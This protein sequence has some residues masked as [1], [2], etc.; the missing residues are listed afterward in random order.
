MFLMAMLLSGGVASAQVVVKGNVYG[1]GELGKVETN[2][3]VTINA[4]S[5]TEG[6]VFGGGKGDTL[7]ATAGAV[8][9]NTLV[10]M[11]GGSVERSI[12]G[13]GAYGSVGTF[14]EF[15]TVVYT[16]SNQPNDTA[17]VPKTCSSGGLAKV[18]VCGGSVGVRGSLMPWSDHNP[19][20][21]DRG[22]IFCG[23]QGHADSILS[24][25]AVAL[26]VVDSTYLEI[27]G[28]NG[29]PVITASVYGGCENGLVLGNTY[30]KIMGGQIGTGFVSKNEVNHVLVGQWDEKYHDT[31][32]DNATTYVREENIAQINRIA[33]KFHECDAW[34]FGDINNHYNVYDILDSNP[35]T[36]SCD[37]A[38][39]TGQSFFGNVFGGGSGYYPIATGLW[40]HTA[41]QVNG[42]TTVEITGGH[43]LTNVYG[44]NEITDVLGKTTVVM[45][46]GT[47]GIPRTQNGIEGRPLSG[48]LYGAGKGDPRTSFNTKTNV[49]S[50]VVI[51]NGGVIF[52]SVYGGGED[53]HVIK[54]TKVTI[55]ETN[56]AKPLVIGTFGFTEHEGNVFGAG[57][58]LYRY[59][60]TAGTV[61]GNTNIDIKS[62]IILGNVYGGGTMASVGTY[63][64]ESNN[65]QLYGQMQSGPEHGH[66]TINI[67]GGTIG[68]NYEAVYHT[69]FNQ[70]SHGGNV[71]GGSKGAVMQL[72]SNTVNDIWLNLAKV[73]Q[74]DITIDQS[75]G[76]TTS[77]KGNIY[78]GGEFG[79]VTENTYITIENGT[80]WR[81]VYG[82]GHGDD[83]T[84]DYGLSYTPH[85]HAGRVYGNTNIAVNGGWIKKSVYG[86][87]ELA[88][89]GTIDID[90]CEATTL[91]MSWP[92][93]FVYDTLSDGSATGKTEITVRGGRIGTTGKDFMGPWKYENNQW[94]PVHFENGVAVAY[95][96]TTEDGREALDD[97]CEDNGDIYGGSKGKAMAEANM[98]Y[99]G[100][101][102]ETVITVSYPITN[103]ATPENY[104]PK[105]ED[106]DVPEINHGIGYYPTWADWLTWVNRP[107][108]HIPGNGSQACITG[109]VYGGAEEGHVDE[110]TQI[111]LNNGLVGH[112]I[113]GGGKGKGKVG[114]QPIPT[115]GKVYGN[116]N[117][118]IEGGYVVRS[119]FGGGNLASVGKGNYI[120][121]E[122]GENGTISSA[123]L[124]AAASSGIATIN[125]NGGQLGMLPIDTV[126][127]GTLDPKSV[128]KD[129]IPYG[130]VFGG[131]RGQVV[132]PH[133]NNISDDFFGFI[134]KTDVTIGS[135]TSTPGKPLIYGSVYGG[136]QDGHVRRKTNVT[137]NAGEIGLEYVDST[138]AVNALGDHVYTSDY[139]NTR[140]NVYG[141]GSGISQYK[142]AQD[143]K[144]YS[145][146]AGMSYDSAN[147]TIN[148]GVIHRIVYGGGSLASV[149]GHSKVTINSPIG[150]ASNNY[151]DVTEYDY[152]GYVFGAGRGILNSEVDLFNFATTGSTEVNIASDEAVVPGNVYG[153]GAMGQVKGSTDV[154]ITAG[155]VGT[156][157]YDWKDSTKQHQFYQN[158]YPMDTLF[159]TSGGMVFGGGKGDK[160]F[161]D[162][163]LVRDSAKVTL[164]GGQ[165][166]FNIYGGGEVAS[167]GLRDAVYDSNNEIVDFKPKTDSHGADSTGL[168][169][170]TLLGG[171]V[172]PSP[173]VGTFSGQAYNIPNGLNGLDGFVFGGGKG[174][175]DDPITPAN[176]YGQYYELA[177]V[178]HTLVIMNMDMPTQSDSISNRLWGSIYGGAEDGHVL[179]S[180]T[181]RYINGLLGSTGTSGFDGNIFGGGRNDSK[182]NYSAGRTRGNNTVEMTG[183]QIF[184][185]IYGGGRLALTGV[186][187]KGDQLDGT[188]Y[189]HT[190][191]MVKG[192]IVGN[193]T[194]TNA[195]T[196][197][198]NEM[199]VEV[200]SA[201]SMGSIYGGGR[202]DVSGIDG[203]PAASALRLGLVKNTEV[204]ISDTLG[205]N[206]H[207]YGIVF[208]GGEVANV[209][210]YTWQTTNNPSAPPT[211]SNITLTE[212][213][214]KVTISGGT[215]GGDR[216]KMRYEK[217]P[218]PK[219]NI[220]P[221]YN[222]D[223]GY[224]YGGGEGISDNPKY[225]PLVQEGPNA[226]DATRLVNLFATVNNTEV[227]VSGGWVKGSV[228]GGAEAGHVRGNTLV[229]I[230]GGQIGAGDDTI[231]KKDWLYQDN[232][233]IRPDTV[234][235]TEALSLFGTTHWRFGDT[236]IS[237]PGQANA[238]TTVYYPPYDPVLARIDSIP[239]DGKSWFGN[240]F[241][242]GSGWFPYIDTLFKANGG[243]DTIRSRWNPLCGKV[244]GNTH[245]VVEGGHILNNVYGAN[246]ATDIGG[247]AL[248][249]IKGG[250][251]GVPRTKEQIIKQPCSGYVFGG[252]CGDPREVFDT[253]TLVDSTTVIVTGG[254]IYGSVYGGAED[255]HV[256][257][258]TSVTVNQNDGTTVIGCAGLS[259]A[260]GNIFGGGRNF[261]GGNRCAGRIEGNIAVTM[262]SGTILGSI[263][264]GGRQALAG[265]NAQGVFPNNA[266]AWPTDKHGN[267]TINV[268]GEATTSGGVT[269]YTTVIGNGSDQGIHL[270]TESDESVGDIFGSGKGDT[271]NYM[272][273]V[274]GRVTNATINITGS[275]RIHGA[276]FGGGEMASL[277]WWNNTGEFYDNTGEAIVTIGTDRGNDNPVIGTFLEQDPNYL[278]N[279]FNIAGITKRS[280]W[281]MIEEVNGATRLLHSC[282]GNVFGGCQGD[283]DFEDWDENDN[284][285]WNEW[286]HMGRSRTAT[287]TIYGGTIMSNV[288]G[289][290][291]QGVVAGDTRVSI[292]GGTIGKLLTDSQGEP[293]K[294]G[295]VY[296]AGYGSDDAQED[297]NVVWAFG[298]RTRTDS[299][300]GRTFG[301]S[302][303]NILG[304]TI[305]NSVFGGGAFAFVG[306]DNNSNT[307]DATV[308]IG[309]ATHDSYSVKGNFYGGNNRRG[310]VEGD[311]TVNVNAGTIGTNTT[312]SDVF[313]GGYGELTKTDGNVTVNFGGAIDENS[314]ASTNPT[315][316]GDIYGGS[317]YGTVNND[318]NDKTT[319]NIRNGIIKTRVENSIRYGGD[320]Y[321]GGL[322]VSG[323]SQKGVVY[324]KI[325]VN[326]GDS[327]HEP[328]VTV[329]DTSRYFGFATIENNVYG[330]NNTGGS[331]KADAI[332]NIFGTDH[333]TANSITGNEFAID[334]VFGGGN[335]APDTVSGVTAYVNIFGCDNTIRRVFGGGD[336]SDS[337]NVCTDIQGGRF[338]AVFGGGNGE[339]YSTTHP[340]YAAEILGN[341][342]LGIHGGEVA[343]FFAGSNQH[344]VIHGTTTVVVDS[345]GPCAEINI[346][347]FFCG[348]N[349]V[350]IIG[351]VNATIDC[352]QG[353]TVSNLYGGCN[354]AKILKRPDGTGG[355]VFLTVNGGT[356]KNIY[357]GSKG[358]I[359]PDNSSNNFS[360]DI[361]GDIN[362][363][364]QGGTIDTIFG[365]CNILGNVEGKIT[366]NVIDTTN[367]CDLNIYNVYGGGR[368]AAYAPAHDSIKI[369]SPEVNIIHGTVIKEA[370]TV[371]GETLY[372]GNVF[373]GGYHADITSSPKVTIGYDKNAAPTNLSN[374]V[375]TWLTTSPSTPEATVEG[376]VYGAGHEATVVGNP[377][378][379]LNGASKV[380][381][382]GNVYGGG[383]NAQVTGNAKVEIKEP[384]TQP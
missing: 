265:V 42:N 169:M 152:G 221:R 136:G 234:F 235:I 301:N 376:N 35:N 7:V 299:L 96:I 353:M 205:H 22:W 283:V 372:T 346:D 242:G 344:G 289:G 138:H 329:A 319:V 60:L 170:V 277:G 144:H 116:T 308:N 300:A 153:G 347:E 185:N 383:K 49:D 224:V 222:D 183:G 208:G 39:Y 127:G 350:N 382:K 67:T 207:V 284:T 26:G 134:N 292:Y 58:G 75:A 192:G 342:A 247:N 357:G 172:G 282:T 199:V 20:D 379:I 59:A 51:V 73:K 176:L 16:Y 81:D 79:T 332:V 21:D 343:A 374:I 259:T 145:P 148:G 101:V 355:N 198:P 180:D 167:V 41:G 146:I 130:S 149:E 4:N 32:W 162:A 318:G 340:E 364:I 286:P 151:H 52:G 150:V 29:N 105:K 334:Q 77:I 90:K 232:Q 229:K 13:G 371:N 63:L 227:T 74:T 368:G 97:A 188:G 244:W 280:E 316:W 139:W 163:G 327:I 322:G 287:V 309:D 366:V 197:D 160:G 240:V 87:G 37:T 245:V 233:F 351:D 220:Y 165:V 34:D 99:L 181:V 187:M 288:H 12:Y 62:G 72:N 43:I 155:I 295:N 246:E 108:A 310:S 83:D 88:S 71:F 218:D 19:N 341:A 1:G 28:Q 345:T 212:G 61:S 70:F 354:R 377:H 239:S 285:T 10:E 128:V 360:A 147:V 98:L 140:G 164:R 330:C 132:E 253:I 278:T 194:K 131:C 36:Y 256:L 215:I 279:N 216:A 291:E 348:G 209:G 269:T 237:N 362:L 189:G 76:K 137:V 210:K 252:G 44:G 100:N 54:G 325:L 69:D 166:L 118:T 200:F 9:G 264:G 179:G 226:T 323:D 236:I 271:K 314:T 104:K 373:G 65:T 367:A 23:S 307:G 375:P 182:K 125:I 141:G 261:L 110:N 56:P 349:Y 313:G 384:T 219:Y 3:T 365:G 184:G 143:K 157:A 106:F 92:Y 18:L 112:A 113:Y 281:T 33:G 358:F 46:G 296:G 272:D 303:V 230:Q 202:G 66:V 294:F 133:N 328:G 47:I 352:S 201:S 103:D 336:A 6:S 270:L 305:H 159:H 262:T 55:E 11:K 84:N 250:T 297:G 214:A 339:A 168:A 258:S 335:Y 154:K 225:Y 186:D 15:D 213:L 321:G 121:L 119:V 31:L 267:V 338:A 317:A 174:I 324:G 223:L 156:I 290:S 178:N 268:S 25:Q 196:Q 109:A 274:A 302:I 8:H 260:D 204:E 275:P 254:I 30:V 114:G 80:I 248:V 45:S 50:A 27:G 82:A 2:T 123:D 257:G 17:F 361:E 86:G 48:Y 122:G 228:F 326:V 107:S 315:L 359:D 175:G 161:R 263:F 85:Q 53:G 304:G 293:Y 298:T 231:Q 111:T 91:S 238:D 311:V 117:I 190:K 203:H 193:N 64:A 243:I 89:V 38:G 129:N 115:A 95:D 266:T 211:I 195:N 380:D 337:R 206:T 249:E 94:I 320:V 57:R 126:V 78:G 135:N 273:T 251:V 255:G 381:V 120:G 14:T 363:T 333:T 93:K 378:V 68:N 124:T 5:T 24:P 356:F 171:Q 177:D 369:A 276:V 191:I 102:K 158:N 331:P 217:D 306:T 142:D 370:R 312:Q 173:K 241:G 40:R